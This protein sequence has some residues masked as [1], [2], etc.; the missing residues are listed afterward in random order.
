M[1]LKNF[2]L[3]LKENRIF[4]VISIIIKKQL[5]KGHI[6]AMCTLPNS[7]TETLYLSIPMNEIWM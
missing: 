3:E 5:T 6:N 2:L 1:K 7:L 4:T